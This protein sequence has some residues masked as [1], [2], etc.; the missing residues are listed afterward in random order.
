M[1]GVADV[2]VV[3]DTATGAP[4]AEMTPGMLGS[5]ASVFRAK[6]K[7]TGIK[8]SPRRRDGL[9]NAIELPAL[10]AAKLR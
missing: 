6:V 7:L 4:V 9:G 1:T 8:P 3:V 10:F 2:V 5:R